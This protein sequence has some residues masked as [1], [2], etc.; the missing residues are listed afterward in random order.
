MFII[1][2]SLC[3]KDSQSHTTR[4]ERDKTWCVNRNWFEMFCWSSEAF[5]D[6]KVWLVETSSLKWNPI[7]VV[8]CRLPSRHVRSTIITRAFMD[9]CSP[10]VYHVANCVHLWLVFW[11]FVSACSCTL[12]FQQPPVQRAEASA[13]SVSSPV[14]AAMQRCSVIHREAFALFPPSLLSFIL[15]QLSSGL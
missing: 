1:Y 14:M 7:K 15:A 6:I 2:N 13:L 8:E 12:C 11:C 9:L 4:S 3:F 10:N 5:A